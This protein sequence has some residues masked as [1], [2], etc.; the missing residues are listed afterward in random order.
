MRF[1]KDAIT[2]PQGNNKV[3]V[4]SL[5]VAIG[6]AALVL[7]PS[8]RAQ[9]LPPPAVLLQVTKTDDTNDGFCDGD[10]SLRE[11]IAR[12]N[13]DGR[14]DTIKFAAG[15]SG[16]IV[17]DGA[18]GGLTIENDTP[19]DDLQIAGPGASVLSV[20][21]NGAVRPFLVSSGS[22]ATIGKL[23]I[24]DGS[25]MN[26]GGGGI[27]NN[28]ATLMLNDSTVSGNIAGF[29]G[30]INNNSGV[31]T[32]NNS[33]VSGNTTS[34]GGGGGI[35]ND[36]DLTLNASTVSGNTADTAIG[37][38]GG[39]ANVLTLTLNASTVSGNTAKGGGGIYSTSSQA[40][41]TVTN[42][43][44]SGNTSGSN[45]GGGIDNEGGFSSAR[46]ENS[47]ITNNTAPSGL[48]S[49]VASAG[50]NP[51]STEVFSSIVSAN[52][53][54]DDVNLVGGSTNS[55]K[56]D[57]YNL[58]GGGL[59]TSFSQL[60]DRT[61]ITNPRLRALANNGGPTQTH[62]LLKRSPALNKSTKTGCP[63]TDQR[64][65]KRPQGTT[66]DIGSY[67]KKKRRR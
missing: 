9:G 59:T 65:I 4:C 64:G 57:G 16:S 38:G 24:V 66:C 56:S 37:G 25:A 12:A 52:S 7:A 18:L 54:N 41:T 45:P 3:M 35:E 27:A 8:A 28:H 15:V 49:G 14:S 1:R 61:G 6:L 47:T 11:A 30:G 13:S 10:C 48:G 51:A 17:L 5:L 42:S 43:T 44:I 46:I 22:K 32:I 29:G 62:A 55:F 39:I 40:S 53:N 58:I 34:G 21:G 31:L 50:N 2:A 63:A 23:S 33:T 60:G 36:G 19:A 20:S 26:T 67:E